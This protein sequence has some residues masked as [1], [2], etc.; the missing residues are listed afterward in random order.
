MSEG[1]PYVVVIPTYDERENIERAVAGTLSALP[2][3]CALIVDD[4]SPDGTGEVADAI[5]RRDG[6]VSVIHRRKKQGLGPAYVQGLTRALEMGG[7]YIF[8]MDA[9]MSH[10]PRVLPDFLVAME[11]ADVVVGSRYK[12]GVRVH[13]WPFRRLLLSKSANVYASRATG[14]PLADLTSG[15]KCY[16]RKVLESIDLRTIRSNGYSFQIEMIVRAYYSHFRIKEI[17]ITFTERADGTTKMTPEVVREAAWRV[18][19]LGLLA[20]LGLLRKGA[21]KSAAR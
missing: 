14:V 7:A 3:A 17:P 6:R 20:R 21:K 4:N 15:Y 2:E 1:P 9:D 5:A 16:R 10:D 13:N 12:D 18:L 8:Q 11:N 19:E